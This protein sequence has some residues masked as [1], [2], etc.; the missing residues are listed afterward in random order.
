M[1][2]RPTESTGVEWRLVPGFENYEAS[3]TGLI[4][5]VGK[6]RPLKPSITRLGYSMVYFSVQGKVTTTSVHRSVTKA[7][8]GEP[9]FEGAVVRHLDGNPSNNDKDN[10]AWGT[11]SENQFDRVRHGRHFQVNKTHCKR[12]HAFEG[13]NLVVNALGHRRCQACTRIRHNANYQRKRSAGWSKE[14]GWPND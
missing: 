8:H 10:L 12:G 6:S 1:E 5:R 2:D 11:V 3:N 9:P 7:W 13:E 4:R 14:R